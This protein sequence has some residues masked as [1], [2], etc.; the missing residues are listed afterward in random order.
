MTEKTDLISK[1]AAVDLWERYQPRIATEAC[2]YDTKLRELPV[3]T[4]EDIV[5]RAITR[6]VRGHLLTPSDAMMIESYL[7]EYVRE[8]E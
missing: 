2:E 8:V 7:L 4:F 1:Q 5:S 3:K 6:M